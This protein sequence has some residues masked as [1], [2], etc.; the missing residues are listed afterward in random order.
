VAVVRRA[1][2]IFFIVALV[3]AI[4]ALNEGNLNHWGTTI[5]LIVIALAAVGVGI[6]SLRA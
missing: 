5:V 4:A 2:L 1:P 6:L 3:F